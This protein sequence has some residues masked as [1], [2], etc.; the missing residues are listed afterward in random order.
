MDEILTIKKKANINLTKFITNIDP[1][2]KKQALI[3]KSMFFRALKHK[4]HI[5]KDEKLKNHIEKTAYLKFLI[6]KYKKSKVKQIKARH[7]TT[8]HNKLA[9]LKLLITATTRICNSTVVKVRFIFNL[10]KSNKN[11]FYTFI[12]YKKRLALNLRRLQEK[13]RDAVHNLSDRHKI[14][15][16]LIVRLELIL[17]RRCLVLKESAFSMIFQY[18]IDNEDS[19]IEDLYINYKLLKKQKV[20]SIAGFA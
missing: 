2:I 17:T 13:N 12:Q 16:S 7:F 10:L 3:S 18:S 6:N 20:S 1:I 11:A 19:D 15:A 8:W 4:Y 5:D 14:T 9:L